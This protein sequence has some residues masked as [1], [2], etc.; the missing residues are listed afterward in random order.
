M[1]KPLL[2]AI[3][4][5]MTIAMNV[6]GLPMQHE[7]KS[8]QSEKSITQV[9]KERTSELMSIHGVI[10]TGEGRKDGHPSVLVFVV[11]KT[12]AISSKI[13]KTLDGYPVIV[14]ETGRVKPM[15][16]P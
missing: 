12:K 1:M 3:V 15:K 5:A 7:K 16:S 9:L 4:G 14:R 13:P 10:G 8:I 6:N 11:K 2:V